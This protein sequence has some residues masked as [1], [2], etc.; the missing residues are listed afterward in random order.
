MPGF[1]ATNIAQPSYKITNTYPEKSVFNCL[2][3][4]GINMQRN[5]LNSFLGDK[6]FVENETH[7]LVT[8]GL[9]I[10]SEQ[11]KLK[12]GTDNLA[13]AVL[14]LLS[15]KEKIFDELGHLVSGAV[16][17]KQKKCWTVF[18]NPTGDRAIFYYYN[19]TTKFYIFG[20]QLN[21][22]T[23]LMEEAN[24]ARIP[25]QHGL[26]CLLDYGCFLD[27]ST[28]IRDIKRLYPGDYLQIN[29][30]GL[31]VGNYYNAEIESQERTLEED[32]ERLDT[33]FLN[34]LKRLI[35]K[36][37][38]YGLKLI[39]DISGGL[40]SRIIC[41]AL[42]RLECN[43]TALLSYG[44][45]TSIEIEIARKIAMDLNM[46]WYFKSI[47]NGKIVKQIDQILP[48]NSGTAF[49]FG[50]TGGKD[51]LEI[52]DHRICGLELTGLLG[53]I[54]ENAMVVEDGTQLPNAEYERFRPS[55]LLSID[56]EYSYSTEIKRFKT[57]EL[58]WFY[59]RGMLAGMSPFLIRQNFIEP[60][61]PF[62]DPEF[63]KTFFSIPWQKRVKE[64]VLTNWFIKK[65]PEAAR[66]PYAAT[67]VSVIKENSLW[68]KLY[69]RFYYKKN[70]LIES[71]GKPYPNTMNPF[72]YW[73]E[74]DPSLLR[75]MD[76]YFEQN[77]VSVMALPQLTQRLK[78][79]YYSSPDYI[80]KGI[81]LTV[82]GYYKNFIKV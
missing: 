58:F 19:P 47:D 5:V 69:S 68:S 24:I 60:V 76:D 46:D 26:N 25:D 57:N 16:Y 41:Y 50:I 37:E 4:Q 70:R 62:G 13:Q 29:Q 42:K 31:F 77:I 48:L 30:D 22:I 75:F 14:K 43:N 59:T 20:S 80:G 38:E 56:P 45:S 2:Q 3:Y 63:L 18:T 64:R 34:S 72:D 32:I 74:R 10:N 6:L 67:G 71:M 33:A 1:F 79:L 21:Y 52:L 78:E 7:L 12:F 27:D 23:D 65:Y 39:A 28:G 40:D 49:Y 54:Y 55:K 51:F 9:I 82:L 44:Q 73:L 11:I 8:D 17:E 61:T 66:F 36:N 35:D 15:E 81:A 53:D